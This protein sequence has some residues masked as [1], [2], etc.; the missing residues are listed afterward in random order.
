M[1]VLGRRLQGAV[2]SKDGIVER[3]EDLGDR[4]VAGDGERGEEVVGRVGEELAQRNLRAGE[5]DGLAAKGPESAVG[6]LSSTRRGQSAPEIFLRV[7][8]QSTSARARA[9]PR[10]ALGRTSRNESAE[11][12]KARVSV[13]CRMRKPSQA[14]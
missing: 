8:E 5:D 1:K 3:E 13:P 6:P 2:S 12:V 7:R 4:V 14:A 10:R 9:T 11:A